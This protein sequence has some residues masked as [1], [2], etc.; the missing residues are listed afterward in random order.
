MTLR[1][2][3]SKVRQS[4]CQGQL[5]GTNYTEQRISS[6]G[7]LEGEGGKER[8]RKSGGLMKTHRPRFGP[9]FYKQTVKRKL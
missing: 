6:Q 9:G 7:A 1:V 4:A 8:A 3:E 5:Y 2:Q